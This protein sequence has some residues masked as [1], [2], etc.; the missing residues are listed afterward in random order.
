MDPY[1]NPYVLL[2][3]SR[4]K[5]DM[6]EDLMAVE[7]MVEE[8]MVG[9]LVMV[10]L[11]TTSLDMVLGQAIT[12]TDKEATGTTTETMALTQAIAVPALLPSAV[13]AA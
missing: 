11:V 8:A 1:G 9:L 12:T 7:A 13:V 5:A 10:S 2:A 4:T 3:R 6:A